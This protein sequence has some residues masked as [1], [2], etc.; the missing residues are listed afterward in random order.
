MSRSNTLYLKIGIATREQMR[1]RTIAIARG[2]YVA[3]SDEPRIWFTSLDAVYRVF[4]EQNMLLLEILRSSPKLSIQDLAEQ[5]KKSHD[6]INER[7]HSLGQVGLLEIEEN[8]EGSITGFKMPLYNKV[9]AEAR[10]GRAKVIWEAD[11]GAHV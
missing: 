10:T 6:E 1:D 8:E 7:L 11:I 9:K 2:Q 3:A 5:V 4:S